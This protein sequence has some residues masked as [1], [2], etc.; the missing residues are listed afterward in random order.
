M[1]N[2]HANAEQETNK[3]KMCEKINYINKN[4]IKEVMK[5]I[6]DCNSVKEGIRNKECVKEESSE[7][8]GNNNQSA[9]MHSNLGPLGVQ[10][11]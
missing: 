8:K 11:L 6:K 10:V 3:H 7:S 5:E 9:I 4:R 2:E 1:I